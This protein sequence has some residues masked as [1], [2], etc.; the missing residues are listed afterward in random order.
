M[1]GVLDLQGD[2]IEHLDHLDRLGIP[3]RRVKTPADLE[4]LRGLII[5]GGRALASVGCSLLVA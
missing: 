3:F 4:G 5:P 2:V 1:I